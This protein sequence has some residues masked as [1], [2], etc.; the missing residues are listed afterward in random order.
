M[1]NTDYYKILGIQQDTE[2][3]EIKKAYKKLAIRYHP[4]RNKDDE[5]SA[6][7][8]SRINEAYAVLSNPDK[9]ADYDRLRNRFGGE[10]AYRFRQ[11]HTYE[12]ILRNSDIEKVFQEISDSFGIRGLNELFK[13][14]GI[15]GG[16]FFFFGTFGG[17]GKRKPS[18][19]QAFPQKL[20]H[21]MGTRLFK[22]IMTNLIGTPDD[23]MDIYET[24]EIS[25][26]QAR[27]GGPYAYYYKKMDKKL[28]VKIPPGITE[29]HKIRLKGLGLKHPDTEETGDL[30]LKIQMKEPLVSRMKNF[31]LK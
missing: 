19:A 12:D 25:R 3:S 27:E 17:D 29:G 7:K 15:Q 5:K 10:A 18:S 23:G 11:D 24:L 8:M 31:F 22:N 6:E 14:N 20:F 13:T 2:P 9:K 16:G 1:D 26:K 4:D 28:I 30:Y 21:E